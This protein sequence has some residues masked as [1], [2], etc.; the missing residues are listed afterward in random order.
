MRHKE[1]RA[2]PMMIICIGEVVI[3]WKRKDVI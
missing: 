2:I 1:E 3:N